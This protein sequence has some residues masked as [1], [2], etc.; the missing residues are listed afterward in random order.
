MDF[1]KALIQIG[2]INLIS[3]I[4]WMHD[5][6]NIMNDVTVSYKSCIESDENELAYQYVMNVLEAERKLRLLKTLTTP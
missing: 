1:I 3:D 6:H 4:C 2:G 5:I